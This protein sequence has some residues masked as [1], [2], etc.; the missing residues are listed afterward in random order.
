[1]VGKKRRQQKMKKTSNTERV[2]TAQPSA[3][4]IFFYGGFSTGLFGGRQVARARPR[5]SAPADKNRPAAV[6][7]CAGMAFYAFPKTN[8]PRFLKGFTPKTFSA[9]AR[10]AKRSAMKGGTSGMFLFCGGLCPGVFTKENLANGGVRLTRASPDGEDP[11]SS[12]NSI[13]SC[14]PRGC[15]GREFLGKNAIR[16]TFFW[17]E[18]AWLERPFFF[19]LQDYELPFEGL[20]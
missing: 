7:N 12:P 14:G 16:P 19:R 4:G 5:Q 10:F 18:R 15:A 13:Q 9:N 11:L 1:L 20:T 6:A 2:E 17:P 3:A 8:Q